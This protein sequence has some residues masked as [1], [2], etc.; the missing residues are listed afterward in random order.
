[1]VLGSKHTHTHGLGQK[2]LSVAKKVGKGVVIAGGIMGLAAAATGGA[3]D[4]RVVD[5][6]GRSAWR[7]AGN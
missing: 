5:T 3:S 7:G 4:V 1:M 6:S 2:A